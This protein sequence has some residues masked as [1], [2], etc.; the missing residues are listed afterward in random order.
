MK[1]KE[2]KKL[3]NELD[4]EFEVEASVSAYGYSGWGLDVMTFKVSGISDIAY[5]DRIVS[6]D[7]DSDEF[8]EE[9]KGLVEWKIEELQ[10]SQ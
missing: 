5:S 8:D 3:L 9:L 4:D 7:L 2:L 1:V 6:L 10:K